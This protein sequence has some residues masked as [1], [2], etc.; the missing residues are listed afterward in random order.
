MGSFKASDVFQV[1]VIHLSLF[2][3]IT[4][5]FHEV[6][7]RAVFVQIKVT[8]ALHPVFGFYFSIFVHAYPL[9]GQIVVFKVQLPVTKT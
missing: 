5:A 7:L 4:V 1:E 6:E 8:L 9:N 2:A 3:I